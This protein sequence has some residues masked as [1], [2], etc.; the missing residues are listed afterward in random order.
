[1]PS[2]APPRI[3]RQRFRSLRKVFCQAVPAIQT[4]VSFRFR[5]LAAKSKLA[6]RLQEGPDNGSSCLLLRRWLQPMVIVQKPVAQLSE[7]ALERFL[8]R[9]KRVAGLR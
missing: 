5:E 7:A 6:E 1:M 8:L 3:A 4:I 9:A 2:P